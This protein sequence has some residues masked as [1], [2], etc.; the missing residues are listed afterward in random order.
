MCQ[1]SLETQLKLLQHITDYA[2]IYAK[3]LGLDDP[4]SVSDLSDSTSTVDTV[5]FFNDE[6]WVVSQSDVCCRHMKST[7]DNTKRPL[8][9]GKF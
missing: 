1:A 5:F 2:P 7:V 9:I 6:D 4:S 3:H 8:Q